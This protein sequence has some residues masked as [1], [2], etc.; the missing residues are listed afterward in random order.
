[1]VQSRRSAMGNRPSPPRPGKDGPDAS[2]SAPGNVGI[3][4]S[5]RQPIA[6]HA[7]G[8]SRPALADSVPRWSGRRIRP[9]RHARPHPDGGGQHVVPP[10]AGIRRAGTVELAPP[11]GAFFKTQVQGYGYDPQAH[12]DPGTCAGGGGRPARSPPPARRHPVTVGHRHRPSPRPAG[13]LKASLK[14]DMRGPLDSDILCQPCPPPVAIAHA[15]P[16]R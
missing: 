15:V 16:R 7:P 13:A 8:A 1:M 12:G 14:P 10:R 4:D 6:P 9:Q 3:P 5:P 11:Y 2:S